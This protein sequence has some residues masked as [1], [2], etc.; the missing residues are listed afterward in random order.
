MLPDSFLEVFQN[1]FDILHF[2]VAQGHIFAL[3]DPRPRKVEHHIGE[4]IG[5]GHFHIGEACVIMEVPSMRQPELQC[6]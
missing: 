4:L 5:D 3:R 1:T 2:K 6:R